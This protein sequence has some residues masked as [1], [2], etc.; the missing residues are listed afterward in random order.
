MQRVD[1]RILVYICATFVFGLLGCGRAYA[2]VEYC[3][4]TVNA[5]AIDEST[6]SRT[7]ALRFSGQSAR[8]VSGAVDF[9]ADGQWYEAN[10]NSVDISPHDVSYSSP[11][12][13]WVRHEFFS[14]YY[15]VR[16]PS[17][18]TLNRFFVARA[19]GTNDRVFSWGDKEYVCSPISFEMFGP[20][21]SPYAVKSPPTPP[22]QPT[23][24]DVLLDAR[25]ITAPGDESCAKPF[26]PAVL[27]HVTP[28]EFPER[29]GGLSAPTTTLV[30]VAISQSGS[31]DDAWTFAPSGLAA[32]DKAAIDAARRSTYSPAVAFCKPAPGF[33]LFHVDF[34]P[35]YT[36]GGR[37]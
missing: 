22:T 3:P 6:T 36:S 18:V 28:A 20:Q 26:A 14:K 4:V 15:Y 10:F 2:V 27:D 34:A 21:K 33:L 23:D 1:L 8:T 30:E 12:A 19:T 11:T 16:F 5:T 37:P 24:N 7:F 9:K 32:L 13:D 35:A 29:A 17:A 25:Q 31:I